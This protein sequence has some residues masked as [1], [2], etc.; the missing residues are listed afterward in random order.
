MDSKSKQ[1]YA[2]S[3]KIPI[4]T[5][6]LPY[7]NSPIR[8]KAKYKNMHIMQKHLRATVCI[9]TIY[10]P[11]SYIIT[12]EALTLNLA[13]E[14]CEHITALL[15]LFCLLSNVTPCIIRNPLSFNHIL[16]QS[17]KEN[18]SYI[19]KSSQTKCTWRL[20]SPAV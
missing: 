17:P 13:G 11:V 7:I 2:F 5:R 3:I 6:D 4:S 10:L 19:I 8:L 16:L 20:P 1:D 14:M 18:Q 9:H 12:L 15:F